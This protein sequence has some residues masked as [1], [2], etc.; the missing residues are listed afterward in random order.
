MQKF[1]Q[2]GWVVEHDPAV[3]AAAYAQLETSFAQRCGCLGCMNFIAVREDVFT[4][5]IKGFLSTFGIDYLKEADSSHLGEP[6]DGLYP[7][8]G[9]FNLSGRILADP[10]DMTALNTR[11]KFFFVAGSSGKPMPATDRLRLEFEVL[12]PWAILEKPETDA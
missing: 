8:S 11:F 3:T 6:Q 10:G 7:Y 1:E 9:W 2:G 4:P 12:A 5:D